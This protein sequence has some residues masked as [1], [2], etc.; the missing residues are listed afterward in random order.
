MQYNSEELKS[1]DLGDIPEYNTNPSGNNYISK[2]EDTDITSNT[3][4]INKIIQTS[5]DDISAMSITEVVVRHALG[6]RPVVLGFHWQDDNKYKKMINQTEV[7]IKK[8]DNNNIYFDCFLMNDA[9]R[10]YIKLF[11]LEVEAI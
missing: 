7:A 9:S 3:V 6:Y 2:M 11:L 1:S 10:L 8:I 4:F 5:F